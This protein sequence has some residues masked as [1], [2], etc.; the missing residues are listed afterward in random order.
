M[1][2]V[3]FL[4]MSEAA[5]QPRP[6]YKPIK[7]AKGPISGFAGYADGKWMAVGGGGEWIEGK[8][9]YED[10]GCEGL[11]TIVDNEPKKCKC[12]E[13]QNRVL[14][15]VLPDDAF[16]CGEGAAAPVFCGENDEAAGEGAA[17]AA[18][19]VEGGAAGAAGAEDIF[20]QAA[21]A[22]VAGDFRAFFEQW[23]PLIKA[24]W[25]YGSKAVEEFKWKEEWRQRNDPGVIEARKSKLR[26]KCCGG[27]PLNYDE[28]QFLGQSWL[29]CRRHCGHGK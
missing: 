7:K 20:V 17:G 22:Q 9:C 11:Y 4:C 19:A 23:G 10:R 3:T 12:Y 6:P 16:G 26:S 21:S 24:V 8:I 14:E 2:V 1:A 5:P 27:Y 28:V 29:E 15:D 18:V 13:V 25:L